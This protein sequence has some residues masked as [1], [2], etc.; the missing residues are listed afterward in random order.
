MFVKLAFLLR[1]ETELKNEPTFYD[2]VPYKYGPF[3]FSLYNELSTLRR[4][5][6][7]APDEK[8]IALLEKNTDITTQ[9]INE[10][11]AIF[12]DTV[13]KVVRRY[14]KKNEK[15]L[16]NNV[17]MKYPWYTTKSELTYLRLESSFNEIQSEPAAYTAGYEGK[18]VEAFFNNL[19]KNGIKLIID[20]RANPVSRRYGFSKSRLS[21]ISNNLGLEY[22]HMPQL[23]I[24][25]KMRGN[26][27]DFD[28]YQRLLK[29]YEQEII[30]GVDHEID[31]V[32]KMMEKTPAALMCFEK[33][34]RCCHRS[35]V[36]K[37]VSKKTSLDIKHI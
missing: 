34:I 23:G 29:K 17:Y 28:S 10:L 20:V 25:S 1:Q 4:D 9:K 6:Y 18:S 21:E 36:A 16:L 2:F 12:N 27:S 35:V 30:P 14:G 3:S 19:L 7:L 24:P 11:P 5:G 13:D 37:A 15:E 22:C 31:E 26:L 8:H 32:A 33:D